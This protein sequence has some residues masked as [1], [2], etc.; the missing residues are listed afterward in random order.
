[1]TYLYEVTVDEMI[2]VFMQITTYQALLKRDFDGKGLDST[3]LKLKTVARCGNQ[4]LLANAM[5]SYIGQNMS[6][7]EIVH[8]RGLSLLVLQ[9]VD[10]NSHGP[11]KVNNVIFCPNTWT[12]RQCI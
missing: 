6:T 9:S 1:M 12:T 8:W 11:D 10:C 5:K 4:K 2:C 7:P 3:F